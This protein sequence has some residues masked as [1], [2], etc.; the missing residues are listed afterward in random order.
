MKE[1]K[2]DENN[3]SSRSF[4]AEKEKIEEISLF[5]LPS[6]IG[7]FLLQEA[8]KN[9][10]FGT[11]NSTETKQYVFGKGRLQIICAFG[12]ISDIC[13]RVVQRI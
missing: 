5:Q 11:K 12:S 13:S 3:A 6:R 10:S 8:T 2:L 4:L 9:R 7:C 1:T